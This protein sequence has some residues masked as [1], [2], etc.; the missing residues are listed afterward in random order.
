MYRFADFVAMFVPRAM[1]LLQT[2]HVGVAVVPSSAMLR[3]FAGMLVTCVLLGNGERF[4]HLLSG[5]D[6]FVVRDPGW[7]WVVLCSGFVV[8]VVVPWIYDRWIRL[9]WF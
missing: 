8:G 4:V 1:G 6:G 3:L 2:R 5:C 9:E 7:C